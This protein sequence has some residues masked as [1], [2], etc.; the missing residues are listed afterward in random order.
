MFAGLFKKFVRVD[1]GSHGTIGNR[2]FYKIAP[3]L[4]LSTIDVAF[5]SI[6][7][8]NNLSEMIL[9]PYRHVV[10]QIITFTD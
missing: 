8:K 2:M 3:F 4:L 1:A 6:T 10:G 9:N 5:V 7:R